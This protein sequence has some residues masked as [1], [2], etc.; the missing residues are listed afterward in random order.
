V[1]LDEAND[2]REA[3]ETLLANSSLTIAGVLEWPAAS[4]ISHVLALCSYKLMLDEL[5]CILK[6]PASAWGICLS[7]IVQ[8]FTITKKHLTS[9]SRLQNL[10][11][12]G[13]YKFSGENLQ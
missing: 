8:L 9:F 12:R 1:Q 10:Y 3:V 13:T 5:K 11:Y 7:N 2:A 4:T 6:R